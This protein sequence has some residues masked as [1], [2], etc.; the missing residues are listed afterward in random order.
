[1]A[2]V[3]HDVE[4]PRR[5][6][7]IRILIVYAIAGAAIVIWQTIARR[8]ETA[9]ILARLDHPWHVIAIFVAFG[10]AAGMLRF[11]L[12]DKI[13]V[14]FLLIGWLAMGPVLGGVLSA[15][16]AAATA[17]ITRALALPRFRGARA[18]E[19]RRIAA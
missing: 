5:E 3:A 11:R 18:I 16:I 12:T 14:S 2:I 13:H 17:M 15:W 1:M 4:K 7:T 6:W 10:L 9:A 19:H 8:D